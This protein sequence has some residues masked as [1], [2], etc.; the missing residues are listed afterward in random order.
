MFCAQNRRSSATLQVHV[1]DLPQFAAPRAT[2]NPV[3][4]GRQRRQSAIY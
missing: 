3:T 4:F 2:H 1:I